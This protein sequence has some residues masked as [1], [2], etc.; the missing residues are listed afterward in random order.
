MTKRV[1]PDLEIDRLLKT[2]F[3]RVLDGACPHRQSKNPTRS[4]HH[5]RVQST[6]VKKTAAGWA[7]AV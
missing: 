5:Q 4:A 1:P 3:S 7:A 2:E 6:T